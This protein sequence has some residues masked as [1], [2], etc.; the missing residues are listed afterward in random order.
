MNELKRIAGRIRD[1]FNALRA[2]F[3]Q[4]NGVATLNA[5]GKLP[6]QPQRVAT[7]G[8]SRGAGAKVL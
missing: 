3:G 5:S 2:N 1:E 6:G 4:A 7:T 8:H